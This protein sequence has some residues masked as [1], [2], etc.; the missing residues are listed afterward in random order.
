MILGFAAV[1]LY[2]FYL[3]YRYNLLYAIQTKIDTKG[4]AHGRALQ[5]TFTGVYL[6]ELCLIGLFGARQAPGPSTMMIIL[7]IATILYHI[8]LNRILTSVEGNVAVT[9]GETEP[10]LAAEEGNAE[11]TGYHASKSGPAGIGLSKLPLFVSRPIAE[12]VESYIASTQETVS[13]WLNDP[14]ARE[15][16]HEVH[17]TEEEMRTAY[18]NPALTSG[19]PKLW[20]VNDEMG[21]SKHEIEE[22]EAVGIPATD[23]GAFLDPQ[24]RVRWTQDDFSKVTIFKRPV[25]Y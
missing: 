3:S 16:D 20:L 9:E 24:N 15:D 17:Y 22:N 4:D 13:S 10:L 12:A 25:E 11:D 21:I 6:A 5:H 18:L 8:I 1:G 7:L 23:D 19:T 2:L 14:S